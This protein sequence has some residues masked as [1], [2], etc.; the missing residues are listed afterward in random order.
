MIK[1]KTTR[2]GEIEVDEKEQ[3]IM[4]AGVI[5]FPE[6]KEFVLLDHDK[7]SPFKWLQSL[8]DGAV[9]FV[10][11]NPLLFKPDY[12]VEVGGVELSDLEIEKEEDA[13]VSVIL[14]MPSDPKKITANLKAPL[15]FNLNNRK[16]KQ[17][18]LS[19]SDFSTR[20]NIVDEIER[21]KALVEGEQQ[22]VADSAEMK[23]AEG[24]V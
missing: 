4:P 6:L 17:I 1:F 3:L 18:I 22:L 7:N 9:A 2:F 14:T 15:I 23:K 16:G 19:N 11:M 8:T 10:L 12:V 20:H 21:Y 13:I 5:G 24:Q